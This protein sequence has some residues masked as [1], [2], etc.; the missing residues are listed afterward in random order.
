MFVKIIATH[1]TAAVTISICL[2]FPFH[3]RIV[4]TFNSASLS[5]WTWRTSDPLTYDLCESSITTA[6]DT[7]PGS[8]VIVVGK[9][10]RDDTRWSAV[11]TVDDPN[12]ALTPHLNKGRESMACLT[13]LID[14]YD[15]LPE[16]LLFLLAHHDGTS[17]AWDVE[18]NPGHSNPSQHSV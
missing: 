13:Y 2:V 16:I 1:N 4:T 9:F 7:G 18:D 17:H 11:Y 5:S 6:V 15:R 14:N 8:E 3:K 10:Q 12:A